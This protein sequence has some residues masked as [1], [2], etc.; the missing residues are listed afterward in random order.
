MS[1]FGDIK[2][3][4][5]MSLWFDGLLLN[6]NARALSGPATNRYRVVR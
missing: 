1:W 2:V 4:I 6:M 3:W 5:V